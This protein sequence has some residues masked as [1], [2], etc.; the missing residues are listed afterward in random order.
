MVQFIFV[1]FKKLL[2]K[3][4]VIYCTE[5]QTPTGYR[6]HFMKDKEVPL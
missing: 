5:E 1:F 2:D 6:H 3:Y 4:F